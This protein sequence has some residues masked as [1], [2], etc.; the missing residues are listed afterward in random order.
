MAKLTSKRRN[1]LPGK[2][3]AGPDR[4]YPIPDASHARNALSRVSQFGSS[5]LKA[6]VRAKVHAKFP[7][8]GKMDGG[9]AKMRLDKSPRRGGGNC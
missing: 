2:S 5:D 9:A 1:A 4:S 6:K 7:G 3:F 8:I